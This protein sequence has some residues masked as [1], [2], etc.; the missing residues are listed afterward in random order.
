VADVVVP[1][2]VGRRIADDAREAG[3]PYFWLQPG[4]ESAELVEYARSLGL[5]V[6]HDACV[7]VAR[8][9]YL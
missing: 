5:G 8:R 6:I 9:T 1:A 7:M 3:V 2:S 4:A